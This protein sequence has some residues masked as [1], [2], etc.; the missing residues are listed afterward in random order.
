MGVDKSITGNIIAKPLLWLSP[1]V[2]KNAEDGA[3]TPLFL[4]L[5]QE[6]IKNAEHSSGNLFGSKR[7]ELEIDAVALDEELA[8][9]LYLVD[10]YWTGLKTKE[11][12]IKSNVS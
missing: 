9:K 1:G 8:R 4:A 10:E 5:D 2:S 12:L 7:Q 6:T 11:Q 3:K